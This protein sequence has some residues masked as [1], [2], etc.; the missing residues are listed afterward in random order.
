MHAVEFNF[1][2]QDFQL[3]SISIQGAFNDKY[4]RIDDANFDFMNNNIVAKGLINL[5]KLNWNTSILLNGFTYGEL[6]GVS[7]NV[8]IERTICNIGKNNRKA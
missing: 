7:G 3:D 2:F 8:H 6:D 4:L 5:E 1:I